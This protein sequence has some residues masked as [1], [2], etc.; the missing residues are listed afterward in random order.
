MKNS[1]LINI[2][3]TFSPE[4]IKLFEKFLASPFHSSGKNCIPLFRSM[5]KYY[6]EFDTDKISYENL[7]K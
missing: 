7:H 4:E 1:K 2:L 3:K 6:P 5:K